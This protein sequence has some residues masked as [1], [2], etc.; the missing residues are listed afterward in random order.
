MLGPM[1]RRSQWLVPAKAGI[2]VCHRRF[3]GNLGPGL[4]RGERIE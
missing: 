2:E 1:L 3:A 4:C